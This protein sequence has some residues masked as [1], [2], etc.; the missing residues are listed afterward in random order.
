MIRICYILLAHHNLLNV[1]QIINLLS[2]EGVG[3]IIHIDKK[4]CESPTVLKN[5]P[6]VRLAN[7]QYDIQWGDAS[8]VN[9]VISLANQAINDNRHFDYFILLS[10]E[11]V[12][13][14]SAD[15]IK[16]YLV[17]HNLANFVT[18]SPIPS[19][20]F[21]WL[22][23]GR[24]R[25]ECYA[26]RLSPR[27]I[28]TIEPR[29]F[30]YGNFRQI[31]KA[32][33]RGSWSS[34]MRVLRILFFAPKRTSLHNLQPYGGE[35]WWRMNRKSLKMVLRHYNSDI[36]LCHQME[37]TSNPDEI[38]FNTLIFNICDNIE[39][40]LLTYINWG[41]EKSPDYLTLDDIDKLNDS[42][43]NPDI[44]FVRKVKDL[45]VLDYIKQSL[46]KTI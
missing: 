37:F 45:K 5:L 30:D 6:G 44:F 38:L 39:N 40:R 24:R 31:I 34:F 43:N 21:S 8:M 11:C 46:G 19:S 42:I 32:I 25:L 23:G 27:D 28:A 20:D 12:P 13:V 14:K 29:C 10:G 1:K 3:F 16:R 22:E 15:Y 4:C 26:V 9:A 41:G 33:H 36:D 2:G 35:F 7:M 18:G 17:F